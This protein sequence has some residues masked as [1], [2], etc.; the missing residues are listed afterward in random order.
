MYIDNV[1]E[2]L[3]FIDIKQRVERKGYGTIVYFGEDESV[4]AELEHIEP[5]KYGSV[6]F[7]SKGDLS[8]SIRILYKSMLVYLVGENRYV[9]KDD[10]TIFNLIKE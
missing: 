4:I 7:R 6:V 5:L 3:S 1:L 2:K 8:F 10:N 9:I